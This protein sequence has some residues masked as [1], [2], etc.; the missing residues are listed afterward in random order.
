[1]PYLASRKIP[2]RPPQRCRVAVRATSTVGLASGPPG[3]R[4]AASTL[5]R[6]TPT[7]CHMGRGAGQSSRRQYPGSDVGQTPV[8]SRPSGSVVSTS[9]SRPGFGTRRRGRRADLERRRRRCRTLERNDLG[10]VD[11]VRAVSARL[12]RGARPSAV[13]HS[14]TSNLPEPLRHPAALHAHRLTAFLAAP[15]PSLPPS[16]STAPTVIHPMIDCAAGCNR[17]FRSPVP[18]ASRRPC[19]EA[20]EFAPTGPHPSAVSDTAPS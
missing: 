2:V 1:M 8:A 11:R 13:R 5:D 16:P 6:A 14:L 19:R 10:R 17:G 7:V 3:G 15:T 12:E 4:R 9:P 18:R 20:G